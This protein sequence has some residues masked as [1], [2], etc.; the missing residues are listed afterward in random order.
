MAYVNRFVSLSGS[1]AAAGDSLDAPW[2]TFKHA[3]EAGSLA[4]GYR[5]WVKRDVHE[6]PS[7]DINFAYDGT[8]NEPIEFI[9]CPRDT[10]TG[11]AL[12]TNGSDSVSGVSLDTQQLN[13]ACRWLT[14]PDSNRY[15]I[16]EVVTSGVNG[17]VQ[18]NSNYVGA[19]VSGSFTF[20]ADPRKAEW[21]AI[22]DSAWTA[23]KT[24][25]E[26]DSNYLPIIDF[27]DGAYQV[28]VQN[29]IYNSVYNIHFKDS[30]DV[31]GIFSATSI[32]SQLKVCNC[33]FI[34]KTSTVPIVYFNM[35]N[36]GTII[37]EN[38]LI[39]GPAT[40]GV[41]HW[42][43]YISSSSKGFLKHC[44]FDKM[45]SAIATDA[46]FDIF[47]CVFGVTGGSGFGNA[48]FQ[49]YNGSFNVRTNVI[50]S[51]LKAG[52]TVIN[53]YTL[54]D[55]ITTV[56]F[57]SYNQ[58]I[59]DNRRYLT[60]CGDVISN[61]GSGVDVNL[62]TGGADKVVEVFLDSAA[63]N[64]GLRNQDSNET[65]LGQAPLVFEHQYEVNACN[66][67]QFTYYV[68]SVGALSASQL[69]LEV[70]YVGAYVSNTV[71]SNTLIKSSNT[72][73]ARADASDWSQYLR[74]ITGAIPAKSKIVVRCF[75]S[76][77]DATNKIYIDPKAEL[78]DAPSVTIAPDWSYGMSSF[79][80]DLTLSGAAPV[81]G[82]GGSK[83]RFGELLGIKRGIL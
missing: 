48:I 15:W 46:D 24:S 40:T 80:G 57:E 54:T 32:I 72:I 27:N 26:S 58:I 33:R 62:R 18:L 49:L 39:R 38:C 83:S 45:Y 9:G 20:E 52:E 47:D 67:K 25:W 31:L 3:V 5:V 78:D 79:L 75:C 36:G 16:A 44:S 30:T 8:S 35:S 50:A 12:F 29:D 59:G 70:E 81:V 34:K 63:A 76:Y 41:T 73:S 60:N 37:M 51:K 28:L 74:V 69:W 64:V 23:K 61:D 1:D 68:N 43:L 10:E 82:G 14:A 65:S 6:L 77:Y 21:D 11:T 13:H 42:G 66:S 19:T 7:S 4:A 71:W 22:D 55:F 56:N 2:A 17:V 53:V